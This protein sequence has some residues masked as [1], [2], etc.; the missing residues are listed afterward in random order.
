MIC[1]RKNEATEECFGWSG[2]AHFERK[3]MTRYLSR[4]N[5]RVSKRE[6]IFFAATNGS[7]S[8]SAVAFSLQVCVAAATGTPRTQG[9]FFSFF[10]VFFVVVVC[11]YRLKMKSNPKVYTCPQNQNLNALENIYRRRNSPHLA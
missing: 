4:G 1:Q 11:L 10:L 3:N 6:R 5:R 7:P 2:M 8:P 9:R